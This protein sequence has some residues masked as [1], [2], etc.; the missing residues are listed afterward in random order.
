MARK[1]KRN[2]SITEETFNNLREVQINN[3]IKS[4]SSA[5]DFVTKEYNQK[6]DT[7]IENMI[8][9][10]AGAV[11]KELKDELKGIEKELQMLKTS[12]RF[13][14]FNNQVLV[15]LINGFY[16]KEDIGDIVTTD[17]YKSE[18]LKTA[19]KYIEKK[20]K[21]NTVKKYDKK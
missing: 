4:M 11:A 21:T 12:V 7:T 8:K 20:I 16:I 5:I 9:I 17:E 3:N 18:G 13:T 19:S 1:I 14:D 2:F 15:E 10:I 6:N